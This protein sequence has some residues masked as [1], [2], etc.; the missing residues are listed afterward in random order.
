[1]IHTGRKHLWKIPEKDPEHIFEECEK[2]HKLPIRTRERGMKTCHQFVECVEMDN[3]KQRQ[4]YKMQHKSGIKFQSRFL[5]TQCCGEK[6]PQFVEEESSSQTD[7]TADFGGSVPCSRCP[8]KVLPGKII[9]EVVLDLQGNHTSY[10]LCFT[11]PGS[12]HCCYTDLIFEVRGAVTITY[13]FDS[14]PKHLNRWDAWKLM[15]ASPLLNIQADPVESVSAIQ[16]PHFL[17]LAGKKGSQVRIAHFVGRMMSLQKPDRV[18]PLHAVLENPKLS[19]CGAVF[20][21][22]WF[23]QKI[24]VHA[25]ALLYEKLEVS[26]PIFHLYLLPNDSSFKKAVHEYEVK[27]HSRKMQKNPVTMKPLKIGSCF[28][29]QKLDGVTIYP[30]VQRE[31]G[32]TFCW[33]GT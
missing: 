33:E 19:P 12:F 13:Q 17:C 9:P 23:K 6:K 31:E 18:G 5:P 27:C 3:W 8:S 4:S 30:K 32:E 11:E 26:A 29:V 1:M 7:K 28:F 16:L 25:V 22:F 10:K 14:W 21:K 15:V 24:K 20:K 2:G